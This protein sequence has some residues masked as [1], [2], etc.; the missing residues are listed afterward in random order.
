MRLGLPAVALA[1][2]LVWAA[3]GGAADWKRVK[4]AD[5]TLWYDVDSLDW[6]EDF[7]Y[8]FY[9]FFD[10]YRG[11]WAGA[12]TMSRGRIGISYDCDDGSG[13]VWKAVTKKWDYS[14]SFTDHK[15]LSELAFEG[16]LF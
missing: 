11:P 14:Q 15:D 3:P 4:D 9:V 2:A 12:E 7:I 8:V 5:A 16:C 13:Y 10:V 6:D 1:V